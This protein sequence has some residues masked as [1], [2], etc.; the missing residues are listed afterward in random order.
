MAHGLSSC[1]SRALDCRLSSCGGW[2]LLLRGMWDLPGPGLEPVSPALAGGFLTTVPPGKSPTGFS[3]S[4]FQTP[5]YSLQVSPGG[6]PCPLLLTDGQPLSSRLHPPA[7]LVIYQQAR[8]ALIILAQWD[9]THAG[10]L[11]HPL[12]PLFLPSFLPKHNSGLRERLVILQTST[13]TLTLV[14]GSQNT[15]ISLVISNLVSPFPSGVY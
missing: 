9:F 6:G 8:C 15:S 4:E 2:A 11:S 12:S 1:G 10:L 7:I 3:Y 13:S 5:S 14:I